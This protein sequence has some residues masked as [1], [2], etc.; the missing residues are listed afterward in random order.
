MAE[1]S[2]SKKILVVD[3]EPANV[4]LMADVLR[5][6][7]YA[8]LPA[9]SGRE[10][11]AVLAKEKPAAILLDMRMPGMDGFEVIRRVRENPETHDLPI[12]VI[13]A[14]LYEGAEQEKLRSE[15]QHIF[16]KGTFLVEE[17]LSEVKRVVEGRSIGKAGGQ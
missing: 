11:L 8:T 17:L 6:A 4:E 12:M 10:A 9:N 13:T 16:L 1:S 5:S 15:T 3:D 2:A 14:M 7:G